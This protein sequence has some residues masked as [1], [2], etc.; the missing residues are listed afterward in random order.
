MLT[1]TIQHN[2]FFRPTPSCDGGDFA[3]ANKFF[4]IFYQFHQLSFSG[5]TTQ[6]HCSA[7]NA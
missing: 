1:G 6:R 2:A 5:Y 7:K 3:W 4:H